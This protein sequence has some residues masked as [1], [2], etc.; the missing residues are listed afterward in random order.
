M[1]A[2]AGTPIKE[3]AIRRRLAYRSTRMTGISISIGMAATAIIATIMKAAVT[4]AAA[5]GSIS[6]PI[7]GLKKGGPTGRLFLR[8]T[9]RRKTLLRRA[10]FRQI[11][12]TR[13]LIGDIG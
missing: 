1:P 7:N 13:R 4:I 10:T 3:A 5:Y 9:G 6:D 11:N 8:A 12:A 2:I